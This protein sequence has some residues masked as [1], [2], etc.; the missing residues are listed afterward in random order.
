MERN[1]IEFIYCIRRLS[2]FSFLFLYAHTIIAENLTLPFLLQLDKINCPKN[3][4]IN[5]TI[6]KND[7]SFTKK[8]MID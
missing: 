4:T 7:E 2:F 8:N 6:T 1:G 3:E 5:G